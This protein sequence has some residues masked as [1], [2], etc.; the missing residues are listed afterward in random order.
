MSSLM[1]EGLPLPAAIYHCLA[2]LHRLEGDV[3]A[4][5]IA[6]GVLFMAY[7]SQG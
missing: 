3:S 2:A 6:W 7:D 4:L 5:V 1:V